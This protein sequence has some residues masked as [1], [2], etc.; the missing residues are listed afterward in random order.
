MAGII[1]HNTVSVGPIGCCIYC[2]ATD[3]RLTDEHVVPKG[4]G[5]TLILKKSSCDACAALTSKI[6]LRVMRGFLDHGRQA[7]GIK[8]RKSHRRVLPSVI[9]QTVIHGDDA[10]EV[11]D[12]PP[13][14]AIQVMHLPVFTMP[15]FLTP[16]DPPR[17]PRDDLN[18]SAIDT[19][20]FGPNG[21]DV[22][23]KH[24][25][26]GIRFEDSMDIWAFARMLA[27]IAHA[28]HV[29][30]RGLFPLEESPLVPLILGKTSD[31]A[32]WIGNTEHDPLPPKGSVLHLLQDVSS[33]EDNR[34]TMVRIKLFAHIDGPTYALAT[35]L[36]PSDGER[37]AVA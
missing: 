10:L 5:G 7:M 27:K 28:H 29:A 3:G 13:V 15:A 12:V 36:P 35:R 1:A 4:L 22:L 31:A 20:T 23:R 19:A 17:I 18:V 11:I 9:S 32:N 24:K 16:H 30:V 26:D 8:G 34:A 2:G 25:A 6:E 37:A 14:E 33:E 21:A